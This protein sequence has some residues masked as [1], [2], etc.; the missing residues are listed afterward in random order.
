MRGGFIHGQ[1]AARAI[2][3]LATETD[4]VVV[5]GGHLPAGTPPLFAEEDGVATS[6]GNMEIDREFRDIL[7]KELGGKPDRYYDNTVEVLLPM[8]KYYFPRA[9]L[10]WLRLAAEIQSYDVGKT[11]AKIGSSLKRKCAY[12]WVPPI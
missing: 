8:V 11:I 4:T 9:R 6:L 5:I 3:A 1:I 2:S 7:W 12:Y 10:I